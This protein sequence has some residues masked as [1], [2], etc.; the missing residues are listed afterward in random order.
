MHNYM[1]RYRLSSYNVWE[2]GH[3]FD[4]DYNLKSKIPRDRDAA[5]V[6]FKSLFD[7]EKLPVIDYLHGIATKV[8]L[9]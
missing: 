9:I 3:F 5:L 2:M 8:S 6:N 1:Q 4:I 7:E